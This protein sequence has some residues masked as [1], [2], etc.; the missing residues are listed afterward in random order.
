M[1]ALLASMVTGLL[2]RDALPLRR[3]CRRVLCDGRDAI[4]CRRLDLSGNCTE[5]G[6]AWVKA[7][8][9]GLETCK[10]LTYLDISGNEIGDRGVE[11]LEELLRVNSTL[12]GLRLWGNQ[13]TEAGICRLVE[14]LE[15]F[16]GQDK[17]TLLDIGYN[18]IGVAGANALASWLRRGCCPEL[19][20]LDVRQSNI[21]VPPRRAL[22]DARRPRKPKL[23]IDHFGNPDPNLSMT[24]G[25]HRRAEVAPERGVTVSIQIGGVTVHVGGFWTMAV[26][27]LMAAVIVMKLIEAGAFRWAKI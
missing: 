1:K 19:E 14:A 22:L 11:E 15:N 6:G 9:S 8:V 20:S 7:I 12:Q 24:A 10:Y 21:P 4:G 5:D 23:T 13:V 18:E 27:S 25:K 26:G 3:G 17:L 16:P 2:L